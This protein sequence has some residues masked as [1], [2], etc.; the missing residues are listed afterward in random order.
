MNSESGVFISRIPKKLV[1]RPPKPPLRKNSRLLGD[2]SKAQ[3]PS[4]IKMSSEE[5]GEDGDEDK[6]WLCS[7]S[8]EEEVTDLKNNEKKCKKSNTK[9]TK[10]EDI[11]MRRR[12]QRAIE[13]G[14]EF[15]SE[16]PFFT[17]VLQPSYITH[18]YLPIP[19]SFDQTHM[20][21]LGKRIKAQTEEKEGYWLLSFPKN[22]LGRLTVGVGSFLKDNDLVVG[23]VI[24]MELMQEITSIYLDAKVHIFRPAKLL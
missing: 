15:Q 21:S 19:A 8:E 6:S 14:D 7:S 18:K 20:F 16:N 22:Y 23:D 12:R 13:L 3:T 2:N 4:E 17:I 11:A 9:K 10:D 24:T 1:S 5:K